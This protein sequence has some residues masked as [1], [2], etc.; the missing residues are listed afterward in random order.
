MYTT[1]ILMYLSWPILIAI[2]YQAIKYSLKIF[3]KVL[4]E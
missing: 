3:K 1:E 2:S 4:T